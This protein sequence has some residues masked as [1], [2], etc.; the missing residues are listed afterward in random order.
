MTDHELV[1]EGL[2]GRSYVKCKCGWDIEKAIEDGDA[3][4]N[5]GF[6]GRATKADARALGDI[7]LARTKETTMPRR[8][9]ANPRYKSPT[10]PH[11]REHDE[12]PNCSIGTP[13]Q[14]VAATV[15]VPD[16]GVALVIDGVVQEARNL[17]RAG[18]RGTGWQSW[19]VDV[20]IPKPT[21]FEK[22]KTYNCRGFT[23]TPERIDSHSDGNRVAYGQQRHPN[24]WT[25]WTT[26]GEYDFESWEES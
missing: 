24:G 7:H 8:M 11:G 9:Q 2:S 18:Y 12:E 1:F 19:L 10:N 14:P 6:F 20:P 25:G 5:N 26:K 22:G 21:F 17:R 4:F 23:F 15:A 3:D 13:C 16:T